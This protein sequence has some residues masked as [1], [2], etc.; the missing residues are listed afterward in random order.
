MRFAILGFFAMLGSVQAQ[1]SA[2]FDAQQGTW[3]LYYQ[4]TETAQWVSKTYVQQ[5]AIKPS[6]NTVLR[7]NGQQFN[8][9]YRVSNRRDAKQAIDT[10]RIWG[11]PLVYPV[12]DLPPITANVKTDPDGEDRQQWAQLAVKRK[13]QNEVIKAPKG[14]DAGL[15]V[16]AKANQTSFVWTPGL[17]DTD[18]DGIAPGTHQNGFAVLRPELPGVARAKLTGSTEEP[19]G[20]DNLPDT[21][22]WSQKVDE[23]QDQDF[24][25]VPVLA[26]VIVVPQ[27]Y[28]G[29]ELARRLKAHTQTWLK[30]GHIHADVLNRLNRQ[31]DVLIPALEGSN[32]AAA[33]AAAIEMFKEVFSHHPGL[34]HHKLGEDDED[35]A[36]EALPGKHTGRSATTPNSVAPPVA[37]HRVAARALAYNLMYLLTQM[38]IGR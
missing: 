35:Q 7:W 22:F 37:V 9:H 33:R 8:Y 18:P 27:P 20:L 10:I 28:S 14:W 11:I 2:V 38:E 16:D 19:W 36:A 24:L 12:P 26:P 13:F 4:D 32:K 15:R 23:I 5:N 6:I 3:R 25:L 31:F 29:A 17:K 34:N 30:Y 21:H 1:D